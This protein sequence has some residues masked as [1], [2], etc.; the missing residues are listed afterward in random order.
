M[1]VPSAILLPLV[2]SG[3]I[4][5]K[6]ADLICKAVDGQKIPETT[7]EVQEQFEKILGRKI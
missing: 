2:F 5:H 6:E 3:R 7:K 4:T 1:I